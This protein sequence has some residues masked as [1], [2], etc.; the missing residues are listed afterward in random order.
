MDSNLHTPPKRLQNK[1][2]KIKKFY[3]E[4][5]PSWRPG[6]SKKTSNLKRDENQ[7]NANARIHLLQ[8]R[9]KSNKRGHKR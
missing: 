1:T 5:W 7:V 4:I 3:R 9:D 2:R 8:V 6:A